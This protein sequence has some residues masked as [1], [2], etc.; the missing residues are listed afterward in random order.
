MTANE[1]A[2]TFIGWAPNQK[3]ALSW[4]RC[5]HEMRFSDHSTVRGMVELK[6]HDIPAPDMERPENLWKL[7]EALWKD[8]RWIEFDPEIICLTVQGD[9]I[10]G[11]SKDLGALL[12]EAAVEIY[13]IKHPAE[14][15]P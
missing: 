8:E 1:K 3:C 14:N 10:C 9:I 5:D 6:P 7:L 11:P 2:A 13:D 12:R 15:E 4:M